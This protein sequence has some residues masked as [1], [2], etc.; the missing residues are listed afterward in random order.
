M[1]LGSI[2]GGFSDEDLITGD[3]ETRR[4]ARA[5]HRRQQDLRA[6]LRSQLPELERSRLRFERYLIVDEKTG[7]LYGRLRGV[8][9]PEDGAAIAFFITEA[10]EVAYLEAPPGDA[11]TLDELE[12]QQ[13]ARRQQRT[14]R[15]TPRPPR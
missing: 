11:R 10:G 9:D 13:T 6:A 4:R 8:V 14:A 12:A 2:L 15:M 3:E 5:E 1:K 7:A